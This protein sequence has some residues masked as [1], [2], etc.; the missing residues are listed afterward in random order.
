MG[1]LWAQAQPLFPLPSCSFSL[2]AA[3]RPTQPQGTKWGGGWELFFCSPQLGT[4]GFGPSCPLLRNAS[5]KNYCLLLNLWFY[6]VPYSTAWAL[7]TVSYGVQVTGNWTGTSQGSSRNG[8]WVKKGVVVGKDPCLGRGDTGDENEACPK[9]RVHTGPYLL[10]LSPPLSFSLF[11]HKP[12]K[13]VA[14]I[15]GYPLTITQP[16]NRIVQNAFTYLPQAVWSPPSQDGVVQV[17]W[18][19]WQE[20]WLGYR[21][22]L[23]WRLILSKPTSIGIAA[24]LNLFNHPV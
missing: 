16:T 6:D 17:Y 22:L 15:Q 2:W 7:Q 18:H 19:W 5:V 11:R 4:H 10:F 13:E 23:V 3:G 14:C 20:I 1:D 9:A 8:P 21:V 24:H 12:P